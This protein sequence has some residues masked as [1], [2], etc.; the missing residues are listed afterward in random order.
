MMEF[1][2]QVKGALFRTEAETRKVEPVYHE[3]IASS[4]YSQT[5]MRFDNSLEIQSMGARTENLALESTKWE[6]QLSSKGIDRVW[7]ETV[8]KSS[9]IGSM[10][11]GHQIQSDSPELDSDDEFAEEKFEWIALKA[12]ELL[13]AGDW[14]KA[15]EFLKAIFKPIGKKG[16]ILSGSGESTILNLKK[17]LIIA[18]LNQKKY[19]EA[20]STLQALPYVRSPEDSGLAP[21][22]E[23]YYAVTHHHLGQLKLAK[24]HCNK[25]IKLWR[26]K[27][28]EV[29]RLPAD[30]ELAVRLMLKII[31]D[32]GGDGIESGFYRS[33]LPSDQGQVAFEAEKLVSEQLQE[34]RNILEP[35][36]LTLG[37]NGTEIQGLEDQIVLAV[38]TAIDADN[39]KLAGI[40]FEDP[41]VLTLKKFIYNASPY[42]DPSP[43]YLYIRPLQYAVYRDRVQM[44]KLLLKKGADLLFSE[45]RQDSVMHIAINCVSLRMVELLLGLGYPPDGI[46]IKSLGPTTPVNQTNSIPPLHYACER[47][48]NCDIFYV[49]EALLAAG[50][51]AN[52]YKG[53]LR[54]PTPLLA[55]A[56]AEA[57][58]LSWG[59]KLLSLKDGVKPR[60]ERGM[61][62][63]YQELINHGAEINATSKATGQTALHLAVING[64]PDDYIQILLRNGANVLAR[65]K[66]N[67]T[68]GDYAKK[69]TQKMLRKLE[70]KQMQSRKGFLLNISS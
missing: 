58:P 30:G 8:P 36:S 54:Y 12:E 3:T 60:N 24:I 52:L 50:A 47:N 5:R 56:A 57:I 15:E 25:A 45:G 64:H 32:L 67:K 22:M 23:Y 53:S 59:L 21:T 51:S 13:G 35:F 26:S 9:E 2:T 14:M 46:K 48:R 49:I 38:M 19:N 41:G 20:L 55:A 17:N 44:V 31:D 34:K 11:S 29:G 28:A 39:E 37:L 4:E 66:D 42:L 16:K 62:P 18:Q 69:G 7:N 63:P 68:P 65:D 70:Q 43:T 61:I 27:S 40:L 6:T 33:M 10:Q 1:E